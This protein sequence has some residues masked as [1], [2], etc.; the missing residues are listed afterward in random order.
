MGNGDRIDSLRYR[1][2]KDYEV[3]APRVK[4]EADDTWDDGQKFVSAD[5]KVLAGQ[6][7]EEALIQIDPEL[8]RS[9]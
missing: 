4:A 8:S 5:Q 1:R 3:H 2:W 9:R 7:R 6:L